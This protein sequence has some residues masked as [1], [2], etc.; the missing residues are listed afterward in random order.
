MFDTTMPPGRAIRAEDSQLVQFALLGA[1]PSAAAQ[2]AALARASTGETACYIE[3]VGG[4]MD[5]P[6][7]L[8]FAHTRLKD[9]YGDTP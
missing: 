1:D 7:G 4:R 5:M 8:A 9:L 6:K 2:W 3:V